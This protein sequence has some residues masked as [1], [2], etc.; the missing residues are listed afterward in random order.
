MK[1]FVEDFKDKEPIF[2]YKVINVNHLT[3]SFLIILFGKILSIIVFTI[4]L[5]Y[6][7]FQVKGQTLFLNI[8]RIS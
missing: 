4:E 7:L 1:N 2:E 8:S 5:I 3:D 6:L